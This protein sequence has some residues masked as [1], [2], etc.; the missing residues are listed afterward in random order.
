[1]QISDEMV[2]AAT[3]KLFPDWRRW[4]N[5]MSA[6]KIV[7][8]ALEA[9]LSLPVQPVATSTE[10]NQIGMTLA[11]FASAIK[12]GESWTATC[13][14]EYDAAQAC[15]SQLRSSI[16]TPPAPPTKGTEDDL[17]AARA[18]GRYPSMFFSDDRESRVGVSEYSNEP[19]IIHIATLLENKPG[20]YWKV[21]ELSPAEAEQ[22]AL[23]ILNKPSVLAL[24][25]RPA[26]ALPVVGEDDERFLL[27][28][29]SRDT[30]IIGIEHPTEA[31]W[32]EVLAAHVAL[33]D[34]LNVRIA[35]Q[36]KCPFNPSTPSVQP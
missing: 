22:M 6:L 35:E 5:P 30:K 14:R 10:L 24:R 15:L 33:R 20:G 34:R 2:E 26:S 23:H 16:T 19:G 18:D 8:R 31:D 25:S 27:A 13:Q 32:S 11:F 12:S 28:Y 36:E 4:S 3:E 17:I 7:E 21:V 29:V 9:A 1:M